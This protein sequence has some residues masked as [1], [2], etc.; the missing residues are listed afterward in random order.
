MQEQDTTAASLV[1][2]CRKCG[3]KFEPTAAAIKRSFYV[4]RPC[5]RA[6][7]TLRRRAKGI[8]ERS[9]ARLSYKP[10]Y[11]SWQAMIQRCRNPNCSAYPYYGGR[12]I[13]VCDAWA[14]SFEAFLRDVGPPPTPDHQIDRI[15]N[16]KGY[17]PGNCQW[18]TRKQQCRNR[19]SNRFLEVKGTCK[20]LVEWSE[21]SGISASLIWHR[22][23]AGWSPEDAV[24]KPVNRKKAT[25]KKVS[26]GN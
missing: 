12:G 13:Q 5:E 18:A 9:Y 4:C 2:P 1:K 6:R 14:D 16:D 3:Q 7:N 22:V 15:E 17:E 11:T 23:S 21:V 20:T 10:G 25:R 24:S 26:N 8:P 19:R